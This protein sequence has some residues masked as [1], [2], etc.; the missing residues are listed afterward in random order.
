MC[1][2]FGCA[3]T[4]LTVAPIIHSSLKRL[5]Y[6]GYDSVGEATISDGH[7]LVIKDKG[8][9]DE[10]H[11]K[12][13]LD[14]LIGNI[15]IGQ[16]RWATHGIPAKSNAHPH[17]DCTE[18]IAVVHNG[19]IENFSHLREEL[20]TRGHKLRSNTDTETI[21]HLIEEELKK[22]ASL[23]EAVQR[24]LL[25][26]EGSYA[27]A[28]LSSKE[29][30]KIIVARKESPLVLGIG[31]GAMYCASDVSAFLPLT[32]KALILDED[33]IATITA[34]KISIFSKDLRE[35]RREPFEI[36]WT[37]E[38]AEKGGFPHFMLKEIHEQPEAI[39][40]AS[41]IPQDEIDQVARQINNADSIFLVACG[42]SYYACLASSYIFS[43]IA[44]IH[45][46]P[47]IASEF[48]EQYSDALHGDAV[49]IAV[50]QSG[51]T[52][53]TL[54]AVRCAK[55]KGTKT[56]AITNVIGS[57]LTRLADT[58]I[59]QRSG[60]EIGVAA[61]KTFTSQ[62]AVLA[63]LAAALA[64]IRKTGSNEE[65][66]EIE[67][68]M[69]KLPQLLD[70]VVKD[71]ERRARTLAERYKGNQSFCFLGR[72]VNAS[73]AMEGRLKLLEL[74]YTYSLAFPAGESKHG[75]IAVVG[76]GYPV[77]FV[78]PSDGTRSK[79]VGNIMEMK[80]RGGEIISIHSEGDREV[81]ELSAEHMEIPRGVH[82]LLNPILYVIPLQLFAYYFSL[83][84]GYNPD[85]P[86]NLA[87]S[88]TVQ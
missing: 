67:E 27:L 5:E 40:R 72:G 59:C 10:V 20:T 37:Q 29:P 81:A 6:R 14:S 66:R 60:P 9:I 42:T 38:M 69:Q 16:T 49:V 50:S 22:G 73:T 17:L 26:L 86:R 32:K 33:E 83:M 3:S 78:A 25:K 39:K 56:L 87:K 45:V 71:T 80:A 7:I 31:S 41:M 21:P 36:T 76:Q 23:L 61:T 12:Y 46:L 4:N 2:I 53:D 88:V 64:R 57:T 68:S 74:A 13:N 75:F 34:D 18:T 79:I 47:V 19:I 44:N 85:M 82:E 35:I 28:I 55:R 30:D 77:I 1:G 62:L 54:N 24:T 65:V 84:R 63:R 43:K 8:K 52:T 58:H 70:Q 15:G 48:P 51:E 11:S